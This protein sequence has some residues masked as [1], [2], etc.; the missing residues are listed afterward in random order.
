MTVFNVITF[1]FEKQYFVKQRVFFDSSGT[2]LY[3]KSNKKFVA[4]E[5]ISSKK[6]CCGNSELGCF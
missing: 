4:N 5:I 2:S 6:I 3:S 1:I